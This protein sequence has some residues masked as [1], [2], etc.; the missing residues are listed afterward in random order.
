ML[1][2]GKAVY[3]LLSPKSSGICHPAERQSEILRGLRMTVQRESDVRFTYAGI[4]S[5]SG[6]LAMAPQEL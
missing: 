2:K 6:R 4:R 1:L 5:V 3:A